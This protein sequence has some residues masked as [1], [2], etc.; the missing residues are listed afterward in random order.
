M[1]KH[2]MVKQN[3]LAQLDFFL[4]AAEDPPLRDNRD[5]MEYPFLALQKH[6][7]KSIK[8][9]GEN[10]HLT[11][12]GNTEYGVATIW[13][14]DII[15]GLSAQINDAVEN[16]LPVAKRIQFIPYNLLK[17]VGRGTSG[18]HYRE[19]AQAIRRLRATLIITNIRYEDQ[20]DRGMET[21]FN[22][23]AGYWIPKRYSPLAMTPDDPHGEPDPARPWEVE[24]PP[25]LMNAILRRSG[26]L[27]V[28]PDY[29]QLTGGIER[30]LYRLARK[31]VPDKADVAAINFRMDTLHQRSGVTSP[32][33][34]FAAQVRKITE[35]QPL[36]EY[37]VT[38]RKV[39]DHETVTFW[40]D[41][42]KP[43]RP[44]RGFPR[45]LE[46]LSPD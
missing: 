10:I 35:A 17:S 28:H 23:L 29:F 36:P 20:P 5:V 42:T 43:K 19:L 9:T 22:W 8:Y 11:V 41:P 12:S 40:R 25:W 33:R 18:K 21:G 26:I 45:T 6:R 37:G 2:D 1:P 15:I 46:E 39:S 32:L 27:A 24:L 38:V 4:A 13:D 3:D 14:W 16:N 7:T 31:A 34:N 30:W 44:R